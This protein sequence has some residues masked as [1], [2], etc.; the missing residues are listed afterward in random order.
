MRHAEFCRHHHPAGDPE[1]QRLQRR[2]LRRPGILP[3]ATMSPHRLCAEFLQ[4]HLRSSPA[5]EFG[6]I[7]RPTRPSSSQSFATISSITTS[8]VLPITTTPCATKAT[9][10]RKK[11]LLNFFVAHSM[12]RASIVSILHSLSTVCLNPHPTNH[13]WCMSRKRYSA[14]LAGEQSYLRIMK[15]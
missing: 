2:Q 9:R 5:P 8:T 12:R 10:V 13:N 15:Q 7:T 6:G 4:L 11:W 1:G 14:W 3:L